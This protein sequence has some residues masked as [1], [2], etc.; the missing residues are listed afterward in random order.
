M[1]QGK[2]GPGVDIIPE[3]IR[4]ARLG[5]GLSLSHLAEAAQVSR[6]FI[7]QLEH[8]LSRPSEVVLHRIAIRTQQ[9]VDYF[10]RSDADADAM[11]RHPDLARQL[12][13][14]AKRLERLASTWPLTDCDKAA[15]RMAVNGVLGASRVTSVLASAYTSHPEG[16]GPELPASSSDEEVA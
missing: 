15:L 9:P 4:E 14:D 5:A 2:H 12:V 1:Q 3:R 16:V 7:H 13:A 11:V 8:N 10:T 6:A